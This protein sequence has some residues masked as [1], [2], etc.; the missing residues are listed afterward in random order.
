MF[1]SRENF[2]DEKNKLSKINATIEDLIL[3]VEEEDKIAHTVLNVNDILTVSRNSD[4]SIEKYAFPKSVKTKNGS[5]CNCCSIYTKYLFRKKLRAIE[6]FSLENFLK[7]LYSALSCGKFYPVLF[8]KSSILLFSTLYIISIPYLAISSGEEE[9]L[10]V[11]TYESALL[12][13]IISFAWLC[14]LV[15]LPWVINAGKLKSNLVFVTGLAI[16]TSVSIGELKLVFALK[17]KATA[18]TV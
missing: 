17:L 6:E 13:T 3:K 11:L 8:T 18:D 12:L 16:Y 14:F 10:P 2:E 7:P 15:F 5:R 4:G 9:F 1:S